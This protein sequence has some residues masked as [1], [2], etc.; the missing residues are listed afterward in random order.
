MTA[1]PIVATLML[2]LSSGCIVHRLDRNALGHVDVHAPPEQPSQRT[3][4]SPRDPGMQG[5]TV[6]GSASASVGTALG[7]GHGAS[8]THELGLAATVLYGTARVSVRPVPFPEW[9]R[10]GGM[11]FGWTAQAEGRSARMWIEGVGAA[12]SSLLRAGAGWAWQTRD[13]SGGPQASLHAGPL[14][15]RGTFIRGEGTVVTLGVTLDP[16]YSV[17]WSR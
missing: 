5:L 15:R 17:V 7:H 10:A 9:D 14:C 4:S 11:S 16:S 13:G 3:P 6:M 8:G 1:R 12:R 2:A